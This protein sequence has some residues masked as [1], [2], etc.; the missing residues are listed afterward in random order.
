MFPLVITLVAVKDSPNC[1]YSLVSK[2]SGDQPDELNWIILFQ[3]INFKREGG[4]GNVIK[5]PEVRVVDAFLYNEKIAVSE[6][7][8]EQTVISRLPS[9]SPAN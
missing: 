7:K 5:I 1:K 9:C 6:Q 3:A 2:V 4:F 8:L